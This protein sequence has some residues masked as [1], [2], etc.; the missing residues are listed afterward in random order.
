MRELQPDLAITGM[1]HANPLGA[2]GIDTKWS[3]EFTFAQIHG[4][5]NARDVLELL[6][7]PLRHNKNLE[8]LDMTTLVRRTTSSIP[9]LLD[10]LTKIIFINSI[11]I[12][13]YVML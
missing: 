1:D 2:R 13:L 7:C 4:F 12:Y 11:C 5:A 3:V 10:K 9:V 6:T 8:N